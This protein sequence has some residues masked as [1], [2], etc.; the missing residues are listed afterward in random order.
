MDRAFAGASRATTDAGAGGDDFIM[1]VPKGPPKW[2]VPAVIG[3][4]AV[5]AGV[6]GAVLFLK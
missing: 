1:G 2:L 5:V 3:A 4:L 6:V